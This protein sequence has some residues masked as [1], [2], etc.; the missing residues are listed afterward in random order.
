MH[1]TIFAVCDHND[2]DRS[3]PVIDAFST[4]PEAVQF[5]AQWSADND[6]TSCEIEEMSLAELLAHHTGDWDTETTVTPLGE[7]RQHGRTVGRL[8]FGDVDLAEHQRVLGM[9]GAVAAPLVHL[10]SEIY[11]QPY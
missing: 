9:D 3:C 4:R 5:G 6:G 10:A 1:T 8:L 7:V 11:Y 2:K